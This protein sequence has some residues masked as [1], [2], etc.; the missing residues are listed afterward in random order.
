MFRSGW[1]PVR[2][3]SLLLRTATTQE[4]N[5]DLGQRHIALAGRHSASDHHSAGAV[6]ALIA[7]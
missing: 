1:N 3:A 5:H 7:R 4:N 2:S 6:L